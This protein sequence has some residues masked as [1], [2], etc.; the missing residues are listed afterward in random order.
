MSHDFIIVV[1][2]INC[3]LCTQTDLQS[4]DMVL[5]KPFILPLVEL[6]KGGKVLQ[7]LK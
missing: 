7:F 4:F 3:F 6:I 2:G 1:F 5:K